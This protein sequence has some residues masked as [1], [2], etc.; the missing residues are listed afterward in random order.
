MATIQMTGMEATTLF[1]SSGRS[2]SEP[3]ISL[4]RSSA[5]AV[6]EI[7]ETKMEVPWRRPTR[8]QAI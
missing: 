2:C 3:T 5:I 8:R 1:M 6:I 7:V 4:L